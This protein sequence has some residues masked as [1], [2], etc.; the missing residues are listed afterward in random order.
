MAFIAN[1]ES[2]GR[3]AAWLLATAEEADINIRLIH[4]TRG[5]FN[6]PDQ[7]VP[8][9]DGVVAGVAAPLVPDPDKVPPPGWDEPLPVPDVEFAPDGR[10]LLTETARAALEAE[11][12]ITVEPETVDPETIRAWAVDNGI[13]VAAKGRLSKAVLAAYEDRFVE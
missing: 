1:G 7:L 12:G 8:F 13:E 11:G 2:Q 3:T 9:L 4:V 10:V 5:G 6:V